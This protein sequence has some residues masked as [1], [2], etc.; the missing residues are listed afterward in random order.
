[1]TAADNGEIV[2]ARGPSLLARA[3]QVLLVLG[4]LAWLGWQVFRDLPS[5]RALTFAPA[6]GDVVGAFVCGALAVAS[7]PVAFTT[8]LRALGLHREEHRFAYHRMYFQAFFFRYVPGKVLLV[9]QRVRLGKPLGIPPAANVVLVIWETLL[10]LVGGTIV[11]VACVGFILTDAGAALPWLA[12]SPIMVLAMLL[13]FPVMLAWAARTP[14]FGARFA[15]LA[16]LEMP[17]RAQLKVALFYALT[18]LLLATSFF[19]MCRWFKDVPWSDY[20]R[21]VF[22]FTASTVAGIAVAIAPAGLG[23]REGL[24]AFGL[25]SLWPPAVTATLAVAGRFWVTALELTAI[26][27]AYALPGARDPDSPRRHGDTET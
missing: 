9:V 2:A 19:F 20:P 26:A 22:W 1:M 12:I 7:F 6:L 8:L 25:A 3:L 14:M 5:L 21:V 11:S 15:Q 27:L 24:L 23:V 10:Y 17:R 16:T 13:A 4:T 18:S